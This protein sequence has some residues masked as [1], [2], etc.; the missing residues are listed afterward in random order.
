MEKSMK[1]QHRISGKELGAL[2]MPRAC[3]RCFWV[4]RRVGR[5]LPFQVFPGIF[6][7]IDA[8][9]KRVVHGWFDRRGC[10]PPWL[11]ELGELSGYI[12]PPSSSKFR[13]LD[14]ETNILLTGVA[15]GILVRPDGSHVIV[16][17]KT[18]KFTGN[19][20]ALFPM[21]ETQLNCYALIA[22]SVGISPVT[23]LVLV[24]A[25]PVTDIEPSGFDVVQDDVGFD[26]SFAAKIVPVR[27]D[28]STVPPLLR[29]ARA[30]V[31]LDSPPPGVAGC[32]DCDYLD[33]LLNLLR[34][35]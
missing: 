8:Y 30:I 9:T 29:R 27:L 6:S 25:E 13:L 19:Q 26:L 2:A 11:S 24:Y 16:D 20:D 23:E 5:N 10:A 22:E 3:P 21:Y 31:D 4:R 14:L 35:P 15:D 33:G 17:Y 7:S 12:E 1:A 28:P 34:S 18:A 32:V